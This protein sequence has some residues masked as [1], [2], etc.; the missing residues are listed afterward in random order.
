VEIADYGGGQL[1]TVE[2]KTFHG[3]FTRLHLM[4]EADGRQARLYTDLPS[5]LAAVLEP[6]SPVRFRIDPRTVRVFPVDGD[7]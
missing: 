2:A 6:G 7:G 1:A 4:A 3:Q 5:R